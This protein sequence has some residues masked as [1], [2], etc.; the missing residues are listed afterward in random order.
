MKKSKKV[1]ITIISIVLVL[2][3]ALVVWYIATVPVYFDIVDKDKF[4][5]KAKGLYT[6]ENFPEGTVMEYRVGYSIDGSARIMLYQKP[7]VD[8]ANYYVTASTKDSFYAVQYEEFNTEHYIVKFDWPYAEFLPEIDAKYKG[9]DIKYK[10]YVNKKESKD[11]KLCIAYG[12]YRI[13]VMHDNALSKEEL[14]KECALL[15]DDL[16]DIKE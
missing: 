1:A 15:L 13:G 5:E 2:I 3:F 6:I 9:N 4:E 14:E 16:L 11:Q 10:Y 12:K 8:I 7:F